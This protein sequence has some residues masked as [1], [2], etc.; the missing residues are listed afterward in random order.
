MAVLPA[1]GSIAGRP[2]MTGQDGLDPVGED[3][4]HLAQEGDVGEARSPPGPA[5]PV[6]PK[7]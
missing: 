3:L 2:S 1:S 7:I 4:D 5:G 6:P